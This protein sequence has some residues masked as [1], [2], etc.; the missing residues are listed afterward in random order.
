MTRTEIVSSYCLAFILAMIAAAH[1]LHDVPASR[2][3]P[4]LDYLL[5]VGEVNVRAAAVCIIG[6]PLLGR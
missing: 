5:W 6:A 4:A 1:I 3:R 2:F